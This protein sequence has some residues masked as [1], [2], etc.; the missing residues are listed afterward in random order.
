MVFSYVEPDM[1]RIHET[2]VAVWAIFAVAVQMQQS[3][4]C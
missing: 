3:M 1:C 2:L 4:S